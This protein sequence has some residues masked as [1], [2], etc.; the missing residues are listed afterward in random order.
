MYPLLENIN[1]YVEENG[2]IKSAIYVNAKRLPKYL[3][4][5]AAKELS[6]T[7]TPCMIKMETYH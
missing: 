5:V 4:E 1:K 6:K 3:V 7:G 2:I